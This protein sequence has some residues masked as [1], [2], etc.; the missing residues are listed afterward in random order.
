[1]IRISRAFVLT[2]IKP[3]PYGCGRMK[4]PHRMIEIQADGAMMVPMAP[5]NCRR[6]GA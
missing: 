5:A 6:P 3:A 4:P 2:Q 1:M